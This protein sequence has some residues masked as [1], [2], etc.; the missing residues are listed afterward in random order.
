MAAGPSVSKR[1]N[2]IKLID[3]AAEH[4]NRIPARFD[5]C[6]M[7]GG[8]DPAGHPAGDGEACNGQV[9]G[10]PLGDRGAIGRRAAG[11]HDPDH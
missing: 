7:R 1:G 3:A 10:Q 11:P 6:P 2:G 9:F 4:G 8:I 5:H